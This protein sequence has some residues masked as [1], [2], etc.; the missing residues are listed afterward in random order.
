M[1]TCTST[2]I[3]NGV[4]NRRSCRGT[5][6]FTKIIESN[7]ERNRK[8]VQAKL[9]LSKKYSNFGSRRRSA[10]SIVQEKD[11]EGS[12]NTRL[13]NKQSK[14]NGYKV[15]SW[16]TNGNGLAVSVS[17]FSLL[18]ADLAT[19]RVMA[20]G[21]DLQVHEWVTSHLTAEQI[22]YW[23]KVGSNVPLTV[24][25]AASSLIFCFALLRPATSE[26]TKGAAIR[27]AGVSVLGFYL[28]AGRIPHSDPPLVMFAKETFHRA[29]PSLTHS[30][31]S[32]PSGH[33]TTAAFMTG[34]M[35]WVFLPLVL[36][37]TK[38]KS[39]SS[40]MGSDSGRDQGS[41]F[42]TRDGY[43]AAQVCVWGLFAAGTGAGRV[44]ADVHWMS[45]TMAGASFG[46]ATACLTVILLQWIESIVQPDNSSTKS[47]RPTL[48]DSDNEQDAYL[49]EEIKESDKL[50]R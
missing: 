31:F 8:C 3:Q 22:M 13:S 24:A 38:S 11:K 44:L 9:F 21:P 45:D 14:S 40:N 41:D 18:A 5:S 36:P 46:F 27:A 16:V 30:T 20:S 15:P 42:W 34:L 37:S 19:L 2:F 28:G 47:N 17:I 10:C 50:S 49:P 35:L 6:L 4:A 33:T 23:D 29:R 7:D 43:S 12:T 1:Y 48:W 39:G 26:S 25:T 32:F